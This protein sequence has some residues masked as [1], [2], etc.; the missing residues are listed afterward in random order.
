MGCWTDN[1]QPYSIVDGDQAVANVSVN[2]TNMLYNGRKLHLIQLGTVMTD[3]DQIIC[4]F[5]REVKRVALGFTPLCTN[6]YLCSEI[7]GED[8]TFFIKGGMM[9]TVENEK[10][11][12]PEL[13]HA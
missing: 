9:F 1:Y 2:L 3:P 11:M 12:V 7:E 8:R 4:S 10:M 6:G 5:G 13:G